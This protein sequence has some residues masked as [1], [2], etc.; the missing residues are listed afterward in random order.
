MGTT[1]SH[2]TEKSECP[3]LIVKDFQP[4]A[5]KEKEGYHWVVC[6]DGSEK[7]RSAFGNI[8]RMMDKEKDTMEIL[9]VKTAGFDTSK[10]A[11]HCEAGF[12]KNNIK[13]N[14]TILENDPTKKIENI[15]LEYIH[16]EKT[17]YVDFV[18]VRLSLI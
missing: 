15:I 1:V 9:A 13:G 2:I 8:S 14:V 18:S 7:S 11:A 6:T 4:R 16:D 10:L 17:T 3:T 12:E 5:K